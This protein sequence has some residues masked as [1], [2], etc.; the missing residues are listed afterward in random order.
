MACEPF[1]DRKSP[2]SSITQPSEDVLHAGELFIGGS[3]IE[4]SSAATFEVINPSTEDH[5]LTVAEAREPDMDRAIAAARDAFDNGPWPEM[6]HGERAEYL[7]A[8]GDALDERLEH[9]AR[10][11]SSETGVVYSLATTRGVGFGRSFRYFASLA[12]EF[13]FMERHEPSVGGAVGLLI[14]EPVGVVGAIV[15]WNSPLSLL[16]IKVAPALLAGCTVVIKASAEAPGEAYVFAEIAEAVGLPPGVVNVV[17]ADREVSERLVRDPRIDK[18]TFTGST[19]AGRRIAS[20]CGDRIARVS[21]ELGGKSAAIILDDY[22]IAA[23]ART[24]AP[25]AVTITGQACASLTRM[26]VTRSR[27]DELVDA[28]SDEFAKIRIGDPFDPATEM[29]PLAT[30]TQ[31]D[32]VE[33]YIESAIREGATLASGG[34]R[35]EHLDRGF[36]IEPTVFANV[37]NSSTIGQEEVFGPILSVIPAENE[38]HALDLANDSIYGL[39]ASIFTNDTN[40]AYQLSRRIRSG[41]VGQN[42]S[43]VDRTIAFGGFKQSGLQR[44]GGKEGLLPFLET[45]LVVLDGEPDFSEP[46]SF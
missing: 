29:G 28:L 30:R 19:A 6:T 23:A 5:Y 4:P 32:R 46:L 17:V 24:I 31:R 11:W 25:R 43:R 14:R 13:P 15:P 18:I 42:G 8:I 20:L 3:W 12:E 7:R 34:R 21:L 1:K 16:V 41:T 35:P 22:D 9:L 38:Q 2:V 33:T 39:N 26:I 36:F 44:E 37:D 27:H 40:R 10:I 45:K